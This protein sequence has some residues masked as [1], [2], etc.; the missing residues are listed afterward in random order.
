MARNLI[1]WHLD[2]EVSSHP[3]YG[4]LL[5]QREQTKT[6]VHI[7]PILIF[8]QCSYIFLFQKALFMCSVAKTVF[9]SL[10]LHEL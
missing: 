2:L 7:F 6:S 3:V 4:V 9:D 8:K 1:G 10:R 5:Q